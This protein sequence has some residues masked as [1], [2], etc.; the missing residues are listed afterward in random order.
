MNSTC[1]SCRRIISNKK[2][3]ISCEKIF[4]TDCLYQRIAV[5]KLNYQM[6]EVCTTCFH[7]IS[8]QFVLQKPPKN[9]LD[10]IERQQSEQVRM[11][12]NRLDPETKAL[13]ER[14]HKLRMEYPATSSSKNQ[15]PNGLI[16]QMSDELSIKKNEHD[17]L[18][19]RLRVLHETMPAATPNQ[20]V[21][22][23]TINMKEEQN[24]DEDEEFPWCTVCN[25][26]ATKR[27]LDCDELFCELCVKKIHR[28]SSYKKHQL[29]SYRPSA[30]VKK[31]YN[32]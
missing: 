18:E 26:N 29:E 10:R 31:K 20:A 7:S 4:C 28:Q 30:K 1:S 5:P 15:T 24:N 17:S 8:T 9:F 13:E 27:C 11:I 23:S 3:C 22:P 21:L 14:L 12:N 25:D 32:Y 6:H 16:Q 19:H 2:S